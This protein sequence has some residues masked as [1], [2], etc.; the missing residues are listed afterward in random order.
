VI[1]FAIAI[2][3]MGTRELWLNVVEPWQERRKGSGNGGG[4]CVPMTAA[5][6]TPVPAPAPVAQPVKRRKS[7]A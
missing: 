2:S 5:K 6:P 7:Q 3:I 4:N 1:P